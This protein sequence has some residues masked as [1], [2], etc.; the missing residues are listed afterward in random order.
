MKSIP[1]V[2]ASFLLFGC[3]S[4]G[5]APTTP[6][7]GRLECQGVPSGRPTVILEAGA[8]GGAADWSL[9][10][11]PL[12]KTGKVCAYD[13]DGMGMAAIHDV[14]RSPV[15]IATRL[16][17][18]VALEEGDA[19][20]VLAGHSNG[21]LYV[22]AFARLWPERTAGLVLV[23]AVGTD[24]KDHPRALADLRHEARLA[25][26]TPAARALGLTHLVPLMDDISPAAEAAARRRSAWAGRTSI[27][28]ATQEVRAFLPGLAAVDALPPLR[29]TIPVAVI[30]AS[31]TP[32]APLDRD[33]RAAQIAPAERACRAVVIDARASHTSILDAQR[34]H[35]VD[36]VA[37]L[38][39][40]EPVV[41]GRGC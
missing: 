23:D 8:F 32:N 26:I 4:L 18:L 13:R 28:A 1:V 38:T 16:A 31:R 15:A 25:V 36:A 10:A 3:A 19:P 29:P 40:E 34:G 24:V 17:A 5:G 27:Q 37:W 12:A 35:V 39:R 21:G 9:V 20:V 30:V 11:E 7:T 14:D 22:E 6:P 41:E 33:W 2:L